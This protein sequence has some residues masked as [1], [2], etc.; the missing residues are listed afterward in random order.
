[1]TDRDETTATTTDRYHYTR[2]VDIDGRTVRARVDRDRYI[3][4]SLAVAE[5]LNEHLTWTT[6]A[7]EAPST[8]W[9]DTPNATS[10][11]AAAD[12][13]RFLRPVTDPLLRRA[14][15]ILASP[16]TTTTISPHLH[17]A[18]A[19]LL[20]TSHGYNAEYHIDPDDITWAHTHGGALHIIEHPDGSVVFTKAHRPNCPFIT[21]AGSSDCDEDCYFP[22]PA[23]HHHDLD[24]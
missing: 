10:R 16:P 17:G 20:A 4:R 14:A 12:P 5:V 1:M 9:H 22:H 3:N 19:A 21:S 6:L 15:T 18:I 7:A 24:D 23:D 11:V 13:A 2:V 8:W